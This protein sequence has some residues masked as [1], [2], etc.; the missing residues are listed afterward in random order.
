M[1]RLTH[2]YFQPGE[3]Y[4]SGFKNHLSIPEKNK[5]I[6]IDKNKLLTVKLHL[7][8]VLKNDNTDTLSLGATNYFIRKKG[9][10]IYGKQNLF[11]GSF[12][13][14]PDE[15]DG[16]LSSGDVPSLDINQSIIDGHYLLYFL[17]RETFYKRL[18]DLAIGSGSKRIH[19]ETLLNVEII[20]PCIEEQY[21][22][23][24][25]LLSIDEKIK[26]EERISKNYEQQKKYLLQ[27]LFI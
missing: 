25:V 3:W 20:V 23:V 12:G 17:G 27:N 11:N 4:D 6:H 9:Q 16:F 7:K 26:L 8:G 14:I 10:F 19:E 24:N 2:I 21:K 22:I 1:E 5:P 15:L 18:E 13:L